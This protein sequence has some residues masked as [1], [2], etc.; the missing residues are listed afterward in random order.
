[1][2]R[3]KSK[4]VKAADLDD[5][6]LTEMYRTETIAVVKLDDSQLITLELEFGSFV[7]FQPVTGAQ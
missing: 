7:R 2:S 4:E 6:E 3:C 1:M 5:E